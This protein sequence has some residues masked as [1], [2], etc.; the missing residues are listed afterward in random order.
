MT[1]GAAMLG[2]ASPRHKS[3][4][5]VLSR[6]EKLLRIERER[7]ARLEAY[8]IMAESLGTATKLATAR[9]VTLPEVS[10]EPPTMGWT[11]FGDVPETPPPTSSPWWGVFVVATGVLGGLSLIHIFGG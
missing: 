3:R 1:R 11:R 8:R 10:D 2:K 6:R 5:G 7:D 4:G 9:I